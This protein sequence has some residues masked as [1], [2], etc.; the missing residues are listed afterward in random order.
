MRRRE[1]IPRRATEDEII[2]S[3]P[4]SREVLEENQPKRPCDRDATVAL[5]RLRVDRALIV[6]P[7]A[8]HMHL[9]HR[10]VEVGTAE[11][12]QLATAESCIEGRRPQGAIVLR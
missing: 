3:T 9:S 6:V 10:L 11:C 4:R 1:W 2:A 12:A 7:A 8:L 5:S